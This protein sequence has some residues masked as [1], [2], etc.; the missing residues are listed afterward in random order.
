[1]LSGMLASLLVLAAPDDSEAL[2]LLRIAWASQYEWKEDSVENISLN[3]KYRMDWK[4]ERNE[5]DSYEGEGQLVVVGTE[6]VRRHIPVT[7]PGRRARIT[8]HLDWILGRFVRPPFEERFNDARFKGPE[9]AAGGLR[10]I[11]VGNIG[12]LIAKD[13]RLAGEER[14]I[15]G[16]RAAPYVIRVDFTTGDCGD[17]YAVLAETASS[18][19]NAQKSTVSRTLTLN[20]ESKIPAPGRYVYTRTDRAQTRVEIT[21]ETPK[22]N[23]EHAVALDPEARDLLKSGWARRFTLPDDI[24]IEGSFLRKPDKTL[25]GSGWVSVRGDFQVWGMDKIEVLL[26]DPK[27]DPR[28]ATQ[29]GKTCTGHFRQSFEYFRARPFD[30]EF[31]GCGFVLE[32][33]AKTR[34]VHL[35]GH[36]KWLAFRLDEAGRIV[37]RLDLGTDEW[38]SYK[39]REQREGYVTIERITREVEGEKIK[40]DFKYGKTKGTFVPKQIAVLALGQGR[41][42]AW[43]ACQYRL[44]KLKVTK[45]E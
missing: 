22:H 30:E 35:K 4:N 13:E 8:S 40:L 25:A 20:A 15:G 24:R 2:K 10:R 7:D 31:K 45:P 18:T 23:Q 43:G 29:I 38:W 21:F 6:V 33:A 3:F 9:K 28:W 37:G 5:E 1:M 17:G 42:P 19:R 26:D 12:F 41:N 27:L 44:T 11:G 32:P 14:N 39:V 16:G 34:I 36:P